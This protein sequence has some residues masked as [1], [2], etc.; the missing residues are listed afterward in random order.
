MPITETANQ[1][2]EKL[3]PNHKNTTNQDTR[4]EKD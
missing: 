1:N 2:Y 4:M 3:F